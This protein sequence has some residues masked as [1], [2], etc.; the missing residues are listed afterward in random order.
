MKW[1]TVKYLFKE[2]IL[3]LWKNRL[4]ALA[5]IGTIVLCLFILGM[6]YSVLGNID[7][8][9][10]QIETEMGIT[11]YIEEGIDEETIQRTRKE[12]QSNPYVLEVNYISKAEALLSFSREQ[13]NE[14][15]FLEFQLDNPLPASFE[16]KVNQVENQE[17]VVGVL[18]DYTYLDVTYFERETDIFIGINRAISVISVIVIAALI[19]IALLLITN[20]IKLTVYVRRREINIMKYIGATDTFIQL[21]F[22]IEGI[23]IGMIG[24]VLPMAGI[25]YLYRYLLDLSATVLQGVL[26]GLNLVAIEIIMKDLIPIFGIIGVGIGV[27]G[28]CIAIRKHLKV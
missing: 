21:P 19:V 2:G 12:I 10:S 13:E 17:E 4:M 15:L 1:N 3:G 16:V 18:K 28:S 24:A 22:M 7:H 14:E 26:G 11:A 23:F 9:L 25:Y 27:L 20:T 6:S 5:S 8:I